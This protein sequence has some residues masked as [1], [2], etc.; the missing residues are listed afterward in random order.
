MRSLSTS[1]GVQRAQLPPAPRTAYF[2][3]ICAG[4]GCAPAWGLHSRN[5]IPPGPMM[6]RSA[7]PGV[8]SHRVLCR[9]WCQTRCGYLLTSARKSSR[10]ASRWAAMSASWRKRRPGGRAAAPGGRTRP[11]TGNQ[12]RTGLAGLLGLLRAAG[13]GKAR[14]PRGGLGGPGCAR[15]LDG[16]V[17]PPVLCRSSSARQV[18]DHPF[19]HHGAIAPRCKNRCS[20]AELV[21]AA[22]L[23]DR[24]SAADH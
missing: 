6:I 5:R 23:G 7:S 16:R 9:Q 20:G 21:E 8:P 3:A 13:Y 4:L 18:F 12:V 19:S 14:P 15:F 22:D 24:G 2:H 17:W 1:A 11:G 10:T